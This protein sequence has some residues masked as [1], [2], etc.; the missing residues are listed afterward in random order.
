MREEDGSTAGNL[1]SNQV[2]LTKEEHV[3]ARRV[4]SNVER[5]E[6]RA[7]GRRGRRSCTHTN[8]KASRRGE[9]ESE[10][11]SISQHLL[12]SQ[13]PERGL[14]REE[15]EGVSNDG[16]GEGSKL[17]LHK[18]SSHVKVVELVGESGESLLNG[19]HFLLERVYKVVHYVHSHWEETVGLVTVQK[20]VVESS[21]LYS[22]VEGRVGGSGRRNK[23][24]Q[25]GVQVGQVDTLLDDGTCVH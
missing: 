18:V 15:E 11:G 1:H 14:R 20:Q 10:G 22:C 3:G 21:H 9:G 6:R 7:Q 5:G 16:R 25:F 24:S 23:D 13:P 19:I 12:S 4:V 17:C 8:L 2:A